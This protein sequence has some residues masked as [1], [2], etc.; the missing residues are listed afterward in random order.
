MLQPQSNKMLRERANCYKPKKDS[1]STCETNKGLAQSAILILERNRM[2]LQRK[3]L[4]CFSFFSS[5]RTKEKKCIL[6][7]SLVFYLASLRLAFYKQKTCTKEMY[8]T[9][10]HKGH[11]ISALAKCS[12]IKHS[13]PAKCK[14]LREKKPKQTSQERNKGCIRTFFS[15]FS[16][17]KKNWKAQ[18]ELFLVTQ[19]AL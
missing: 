8:A 18:T 2:L 6:L 3:K 15:S 7:C 12:N 19:I 5:I 10:E 16:W 4:K 13:T 9:L 14:I 11:W 17:K 1:S